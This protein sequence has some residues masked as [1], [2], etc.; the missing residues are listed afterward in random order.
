MISQFKLQSTPEPGNSHLPQAHDGLQFLSFPG[1]ERH[2]RLPP[3]VLS[4]N[5]RCWTLQADVYS[6]EGVMDLLLLTDALRRAIVPGAQVHLVLPYVPY[7]RQD[8]VA[9]PGEPLS[10]A[11]FCRLVNGL[12]F[13]TVT[14]SDPHS[15]VV[16]A[17]LDRVRVVPATPYVRLVR[18]QALAQLPA[19]ALVAP[20]AGARKRVDTVGQ[21]LAL[22]VVHAG[23]K[24]DAATGALSGAEVTGAVP[25]LPLL[26]VDDICDGG[27]TFI[28]LAR[29][30]RERTRQPLYLYV[31][32]GLFTKGLA[33]LQAHFDGIFAAHCAQPD[34]VEAT[35]LTGPRA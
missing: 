24:R 28:S 29:V 5:D 11:V 20:D 22:P 4:A 6:T 18:E 17:L 1:G 34:L 21:A 31:T 35:R 19:V 30:L 13:D 27:G 7:A 15:D 25:D 2:V 9:L 26:I 8:R 10:A 32:H 33:P 16:P 12:G 23:K 14:I 3:S